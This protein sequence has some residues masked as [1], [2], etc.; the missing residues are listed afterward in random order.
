M[1]ATFNSKPIDDL[2]AYMDGFQQVANEEMDAALAVIVPPALNELSHEPGPV[3]YPIE[4]TSEKQRR[5]FFATNG[6]GRGIGAARTH[7]LSQSWGIVK[8]ALGNDIV[9]AFD[10][11]QPYAKFVYGSLSKTNPGLHQQRFHVNTGWQQAAD[12]VDFWM[13]ALIEQFTANMRARLGEMAG[14][15]TVRQRAFTGRSA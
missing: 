7:D 12:T 15:T 9:V 4:W 2:I 6:F 5:A 11:P 3:K 14:N 13:V 10:N 8:T 1:S